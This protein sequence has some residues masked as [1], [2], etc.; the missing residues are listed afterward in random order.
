MW[1]PR[2]PVLNLCL[3]VRVHV[4]A[5]PCACVRVCVRVCACVCVCVHGMIIYKYVHVDAQNDERKE[6]QQVKEL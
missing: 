5:C 6:T 1:K 3:C 2:T 4:C